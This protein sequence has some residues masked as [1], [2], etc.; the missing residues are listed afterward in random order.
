M[1]S[2]AGAAVRG[3]AARALG[4]IS[5]TLPGIGSRRCGCIGACHRVDAALG[6]GASAQQKAANYERYTFVFHDDTPYQGIVAPVPDILPVPLVPGFIVPLVPGLI[7][8]PLLIPVP[9]FTPP[10][11]LVEPVPLM[12]PVPLLMPAPGLLPVPWL[13]TPPVLTPPEAEPP[14]LAPPVPA[15]APAPAPPV[16]A[17]MI[18]LSPAMASSPSADAAHAAMMMD[19][20]FMEKVSAIHEGADVRK[21]LTKIRVEIILN[22]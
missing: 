2:A 10:V 14:P 3:D 19:L 20:I 6:K 11:P 13:P 9:L 12:V 18:A 17:M 1:E 8:V 21:A 5:R 7:A 16:C 4:A 22:E 15:P